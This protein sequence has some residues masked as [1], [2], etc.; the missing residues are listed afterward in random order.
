MCN[1]KAG[2]RTSLFG[3]GDFTLKGWHTLR[4]ENKLLQRGREDSWGQLGTADNVAQPGQ[5]TSTRASRISL[6]SLHRTPLLPHKM[7]WTSWL[8]FLR[9]VVSCIWKSNEYYNQSPKLRLG[10]QLM[11]FRCFIL[12]KPKTWKDQ[13]NTSVLTLVH[14]N[15]SFEKA[16]EQV[17]KFWCSTCFI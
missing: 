1:T 4:S 10:K 12:I 13:K 8:K 9:V 11:G 17:W 2:S 6:I 16:L 5:T 15:T 14:F 7:S 3:H